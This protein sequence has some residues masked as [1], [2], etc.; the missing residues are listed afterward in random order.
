MPPGKEVLVL[1][2]FRFSIAGLMGAVGVAALG[3]TA[4]RAGSEAWA[5]IVFLITAVCLCLG[6]VGLICRKTKNRIGPILMVQRVS[7]NG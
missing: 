4:L 3:A 6:F 1:K 7:T 2:S 5:G